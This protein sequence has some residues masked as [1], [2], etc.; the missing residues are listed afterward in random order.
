MIIES[1]FCTAETVDIMCGPKS[2]LVICEKFGISSSVEELCTLSNFDKQNGTSM[3]GLYQASIKKG[4]PAVPIKSDIKK[5]SSIKMPLIAFVDGNHFLVVHESNDREILIQTPPEDIIRVSIDNF[6]KRWSG[7]L[8]IFSADLNKTVTLQ[9]QEK[10]E[11]PHSAYIVFP[12]T[13]H[14]FGI[15]NEGEILTYSFPFSNIGAEILKISVRPTCSCTTTDVSEQIIPPGNKGV[16]TVQ[17]DTKEKHGL[18]KQGADIRTNDPNKRW[19]SLT[20]SATVKTSIKVIPERIWIDNISDN[21]EIVK[22]LYVIDPGDNSL[23]IQEIE[24][25]DGVNYELKAKINYIDNIMAIPITIT[26]PAKTIPN[27][28]NKEIIF[29]TNKRELVVPISGTVHTDI[30]AVPPAIF[31][32]ES[33]EDKAL[34]REIDL[35]PAM[36]GI[37]ETIETVTESPFI[38][39]ETETIE[40]GSKYRLKATLINVP[41]NETINGTIAIFINGKNTPSLTIP[42]YAVASNRNNANDLQLK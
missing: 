10:L 2:L 21:K 23:N 33:E 3:L 17:F 5:L 34:I 13:I 12:E 27:A 9:S 19:I 38:K 11:P 6:Q 30:K 41:P 39:V 18:S 20:I 1:I 8:L 36:D 15:V 35:L 4:L 22:E 42:V 31:F 16:I 24:V 25:P 26:I 7:E 14:D 28:I 29:Q 32:G 40:N 37:I